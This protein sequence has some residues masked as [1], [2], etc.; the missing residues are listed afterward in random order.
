MT[1]ETIG[2]LVGIVAGLVTI[3]VA[4]NQYGLKKVVG[5]VAVLLVIGCCLLLLGTSGSFH[6]LASLTEDKEIVA[7]NEAINA[8]PKN[9]KAYH[10]RGRVYLGRKTSTWQSLISPKL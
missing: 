3:A 5:G 7:Y 8:N 2:V 9:P 1:L 6:W 10:A 4:I